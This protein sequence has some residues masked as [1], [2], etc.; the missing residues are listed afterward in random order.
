MNIEINT[1]IHISYGIK[2]AQ[3]GYRICSK[4]KCKVKYE[5]TRYNTKQF[6]MQTCHDF[7][8]NCPD[9]PSELTDEMRLTFY[10][11]WGPLQEENETEDVYLDLA[12]KFLDISKA[13]EAKRMPTVRTAPE[14]GA[15]IHEDGLFYPAID[16]DKLYDA[17][18]IAWQLNI[19]RRNP[20]LKIC[21]H[22]QTYGQRKGCARSFH[23]KRSDKRHCSRICKDVYN[24]KQRK[25]LK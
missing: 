4:K 22:F 23:P 9:H 24:Q 6:S 14:I 13:D 12:A 18:L 20:E 19:Y 1:S 25:L 8:M 16:C 11:M 21:L 2:V 10:D 3:T 5:G 17:L 15:M 7:L